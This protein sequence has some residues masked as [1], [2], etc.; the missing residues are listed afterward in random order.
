MSETLKYTIGFLAGA[1]IGTLIMA[2]CVIVAVLCHSRA[3][4][5]PPMTDPTRDEAEA[6]TDLAADTAYQ[7]ECDE[8]MNA[9]MGRPETCP[10]CGGSA[11]APW[12][13]MEGDVRCGDPCHYT[14]H[15][16]QIEPKP[17]LHTHR[18][19]QPVQH[20]APTHPE[21]PTCGSDD[22]KVRDYTDCSMDEPA[23]YLPCGDHWHDNPASPPDVEAALTDL[24]D[25][26]CRYSGDI[27]AM[28]VTV[29]FRRV[30]TDALSQAN[31]ARERAERVR[32]ELQRAWDMQ[33]ACPHTSATEGCEAL[34][35]ASEYKERAEKAEAALRLACRR[36]RGRDS[37]CV[38][39]GN[40]CRACGG[41]S[42][43][44]P[45][46]I[47]AIVAHF[48]AQAEGSK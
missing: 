6:Y 43:G 12:R 20:D 33:D 47:E 15:S 4:R 45:T 27:D 1:G 39:F 29:A 35:I 17:T 44:D 41:G 31:T 18:S 30:L 32:D 7:A 28:G 10:T 40:P 22:P 46:C 3:V 16:Q 23:E 19:T 48:L 14:Q 2:F 8:W 5:R 26:A 42:T 38:C 21:C 13:S 37:V 36:L 25:A 24:V 11:D 9:P 34:P